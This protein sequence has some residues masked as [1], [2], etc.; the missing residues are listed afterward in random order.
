MD[1]YLWFFLTRRRWS[2]LAAARFFNEAHPPQHATTR[3]LHGRWALLTIA[4]VGA[5]RRGARAAL[6]GMTLHLA[7]DAY[8]ESRMS[9]TRLAALLRDDHT[10]QTCGARDARL[11]T[12]L[13]RQPRLLPSYASQ[14]HITL[15]DMCHQAA[16]AHP[17]AVSR[18]PQLALLDRS[19]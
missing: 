15:C 17:A 5:R 13:W 16:H 12:H 4:L 2:P 1:H 19:S 11:G 7:L 9:E 14:N 8:H 3:V 6:L 18:R 10:C